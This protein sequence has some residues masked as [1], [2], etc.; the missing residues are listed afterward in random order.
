MSDIYWESFTSKRSPRIKDKTPI[1]TITRD[2]GRI[3]INAAACSLIENC[4]SF[5]NIELLKG[6]DGE[7]FRKVGFKFLSSPSTHSIGISRKTYK[8]RE[9][10]GSTIYSKA[11]VKEIYAQNEGLAKSAHFNVETKNVKNSPT[12]MFDIFDSVHTE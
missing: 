12:L 5:S 8:G 11:F 1:I 3:S 4:Y 10:G 7:N 9:V 2:S 6:I